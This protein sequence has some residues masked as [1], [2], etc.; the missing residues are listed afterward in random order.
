MGINGEKNVAGQWKIYTDAKKL[1]P[2]GEAG[3]EFTRLSDFI[4]G[5]SA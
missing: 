1:C 2:L 3:E 4:P 5:V